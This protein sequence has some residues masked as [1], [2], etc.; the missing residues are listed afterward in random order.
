MSNNEVYLTFKTDKETS[1]GLKVLAQFFKKTQPELI[2]DICKDFVENVLEE[3]EKKCKE[4][5]EEKGIEIENN[6]RP[7]P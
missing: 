7:E 3:L 4:K 5:L 6:N 2:N 1:E